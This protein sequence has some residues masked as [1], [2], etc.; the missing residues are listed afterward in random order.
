M[1]QVYRTHNLTDK[2]WQL[3]KVMERQGV[4]CTSHTYSTILGIIAEM[5]NINEG[6]R[7]HQQL[8]VKNSL[9]LQVMLAY[10]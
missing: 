5:A 4:A 3:F 6:R 9:E 2:A 7:I 10:F 1:L 8:K